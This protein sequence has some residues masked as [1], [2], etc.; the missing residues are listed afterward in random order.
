MA[1]DGGD[2]IR[3]T[4]EI[5]SQIGIAQSTNDLEDRMPDSSRKFTMTL[6]REDRQGIKVSP[7]RKRNKVIRKFPHNDTEEIENGVACRTLTSREAE[8][9]TVHPQ[10]PALL[11]TP[12]E[13]QGCAGINILQHRGQVVREE[14]VFNNTGEP[15]FLAQLPRRLPRNTAHATPLIAMP[16]GSDTFGAYLDYSELP[17]R[18]SNTNNTPDSKTLSG[19][20]HYGMPSLEMTSAENSGALNPTNRAG[21]PKI[22]QEGLREPTENSGNEQLQTITDDATNASKKVSR[23]LQHK[24]GEHFSDDCC[25]STANCPRKSGVTMVNVD[26]Q[27]HEWKPQENNQLNA[28]SETFKSA[29]NASTMNAVSCGSVRN[30]Y[31][32]Y[33]DR[34]GQNMN[35]EGKTNGD[36]RKTGANRNNRNHDNVESCH[37][38]NITS[39]G[40]SKNVGSNGNCN[41]NNNINDQHMDSDGSSDG[42]HN[43][44]NDSCQISRQ[45]PEFSNDIPP[46]GQN[47]DAENLQG[48]DRDSVDEYFKHTS[49]DSSRH[50]TSDQM[51]YNTETSK[52]FA[53][54][55]LTLND[56]GSCT[57]TIHNNTPV[58]DILQQDEFPVEELAAVNWESDHEFRKYNPSNRFLFIGEAGVQPRTELHAEKNTEAEN[59]SSVD[60]CKTT[61]TT[62]VNGFNNPDLQMKEEDNQVQDSHTCSQATQSNDNQERSGDSASRTEL[63]LSQV[64][65][66]DLNKMSDSTVGDF[67]PSQEDFTENNGTLQASPLDKT[68]ALEE[69]KSTE[70]TEQFRTLRECYDESE[71]PNIWEGSV[72]IKQTGQSSLEDLKCVNFLSILTHRLTEYT[73]K[74]VF[75][76]NPECCAENEQSQPDY[77]ISEKTL[78][79]IGAHANDHKCISFCEITVGD[80]HR[81]STNSDTH[82]QPREYADAIIDE[83][84][85]KDVECALSEQPKTCVGSENK[86]HSS[87]EQVI[88]SNVADGKMKPSP[89]GTRPCCTDDVTLGTPSNC[90]QAEA[91]VSYEQWSTKYTMSLSDQ[92]LQKYDVLTTQSKEKYKKS[93]DSLKAG[94]PDLKRNISYEF[95]DPAFE[96]DVFRSLEYATSLSCGLS[97]EKRTFGP[98]ACQESNFSREFNNLAVPQQE[99]N[100]RSNGGLAFDG[101]RVSIQA[102]DCQ[103]TFPVAVSDESTRCPMSEEEAANYSKARIMRASERRRK[104]MTEFEEITSCVDVYNWPR[105]ERRH[106]SYESGNFCQ[107]LDTPVKRPVNDLHSAVQVEGKHMVGTFTIDY[108]KPPVNGFVLLK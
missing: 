76:S 85:E 23:Y 60:I 69:G 71:I 50:A 91:N 67:Q 62:R 103:K 72:H 73:S 16:T 94:M 100:G 99:E 108:L 83:K 74:D 7:A 47:I 54:E 18:L 12:D 59:C 29:H 24:V 84:P 36:K 34:S 98:A 75:S 2:H 5:R 38:F 64:F 31:T 20:H 106:F 46:T 44:I 9:N 49:L 48:T 82:D 41:K 22:T 97:S 3:S 13:G 77:S 17:L 93:P 78:T 4:Y 26:K 10:T 105:Y 92:F 51:E 70:Q 28:V 15:R 1:D 27:K 102:S 107:D 8:V 35:A 53:C 39:N 33:I 90:Q 80:I 11:C 79:S 61:E 6:E 95:A 66:D 25:F 21:C 43:E 65:D 57:R 96:V 81:P 30:S 45:R 68:I 89:K 42:E 104:L 19:G 56:G 63:C 88:S 55:S 101:E 37:H 40:S 14:P 32:E 58:V 87:P 52:G 86:A